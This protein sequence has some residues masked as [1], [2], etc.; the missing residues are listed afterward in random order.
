MNRKERAIIIQTLLEKLY[1]EVKTPLKYQDPFTFLVA[2]VLSARC[3]DVMVNKISPILFA[4]ADTPAKMALLDVEVIRKII[5]PCGLSP[6]KSKNIKALSIML[7]EHHRGKVPQTFLELE[8]LPGVGHKTASVVL[9][10]IFNVAAFPVDTHIHRLARRWGLSSGKS[11]V[12]TERDI[13]EL[14]SKRSW[15]KLHIRMI[16]YGREY[17]SARKCFGKTCLICRRLF[18]KRKTA[19]L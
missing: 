15:Q 2:V 9:S 13:K 3:T 10:Q 1:P 12:Q 5:K 7:L 11:V 18:P 14:F 16:L 8:A 17:C 4:Q 6:A 19:K